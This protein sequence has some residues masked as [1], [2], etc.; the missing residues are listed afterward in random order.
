MGL[1]QEQKQDW[2]RWLEERSAQGNARLSQLK[3]T[4]PAYRLWGYGFCAACAGCEGAC[5][6][7]K[8][9]PKK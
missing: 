7:L 1:S 6:A 3:V 4:D 8:A 9:P 5:K 2:A